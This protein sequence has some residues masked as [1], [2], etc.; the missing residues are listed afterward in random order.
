[1]SV[2]SPTL[3]EIYSDF[4]APEGYGDK[5]TLHKYIPLYE[6]HITK[7]ENVSLLEI[8]VYFGHSIAMW[9]RFLKDSKVYGCDIALDRV[10][11]DVENLYELDST[12]LE[13]VNQMFEGLTFDYIIDDGDHSAQSQIR[14]FKN[15]WP[16]LK[17]GGTYF[18]EDIESDA[19]LEAIRNQ[20]TDVDHIVYDN[21]VE[22]GRYDEIMLVAFK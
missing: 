22:V 5:G 4:S 8:G 3:A 6:K 1:M 9:N 12:N 14:T 7:R 10:S 13:K 15:F 19:A 18:I 20:L 2:S 16:Y 17:D 21:R 11:F